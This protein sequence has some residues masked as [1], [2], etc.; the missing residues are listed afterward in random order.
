MNPG[1]TGFG[2]CFI[3][4]AQAAAPTQ[5]RQGAF[6]YPSAGQHLKAVT[7]RLPPDYLQQPAAKGPGPGDQL[8][9]V[10]A[11]SPNYLESGKPT[12]QFSQ[13]QLGSIS[14][15]DV[16]GMYHH[17][18][19]QSHGVYYDVTLA[20]GD[21]FAGII[22]PRP[23]FSVVFTDW[24]SMI[25][26]L[27]VASRPAASRTLGRKASSMASQGPSSRHFRKYHQT[28]PQ[29]GKSWGTIRQ[30]T[31]PRSTYRI[32]LITSRKSTVRGCPLTLA[33]GKRGANSAHWGSVKSLGYGFLFMPPGYQGSR[34]TAQPMITQDNL[35]S[36]TP[37]KSAGKKVLE[38][39][40]RA[41]TG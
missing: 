15:L 11:V 32:P 29:G 7:V 13:H 10:S 25:A 36:H 22:A 24:L 31:P 28:V 35:I 9:S 26:A 23:P 6:H 8:A 5:P 17:G 18:Q 30:G 39:S 19:K 37:S 27:G 12:R 3:V 40:S 14:I 38:R 4:L 33:A 21:L 1:F 41:L 2:Q 16:G 20:A 34:P